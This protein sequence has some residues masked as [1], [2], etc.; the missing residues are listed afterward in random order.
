MKSPVFPLLVRLFSRRFF[1]NDLLAP[2]IDLRPSAIWLLAALAMPPLLWTVKSIVPYGLMSIHGYALMESVS[3]FDKSL[4]MMLA[5]VSAGIVTVL[6]WEALLVDRRDALVLGALPV[7][8]LP[9]VAA[10]A[11]AIEIGRAS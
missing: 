6:S 9:I 10:K 1:E 4:L 5:M 8:P 11:A 3:W 2:D 7:A